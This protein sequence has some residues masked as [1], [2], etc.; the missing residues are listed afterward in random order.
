MSL[1]NVTF[2]DFDPVLVYS[3]PAD[4]TTPD[5]QVSPSIDPFSHIDRQEC[6]LTWFVYVL[7]IVDK[8]KLVQCFLRCD[9]VGLASSDVSFHW[10]TEHQGL[11]QFHW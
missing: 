8:P 10:G 9:G 11:L 2:D 1:L 7:V 4:W 3:N 5:P 6:R